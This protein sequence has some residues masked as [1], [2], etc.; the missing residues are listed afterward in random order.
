MRRF[1]DLALKTA[2]LLC[3]ASG[4][5]AGPDSA[6]KEALDFTALVI[7]PVLSPVPVAATDERRHL[8]YEILIVNETDLY[9]RVD[10]IDAFDPAGGA[11]LGQWKDEALAKIFRINGK[12]PGLTLRPGASAYAFLDAAVDKG[13][14]VPKVVKHRITTSRFMSKTPDGENLVPL[15]PKFGIP[16]VA[17]FEGAKIAVDPGKPL[18]IEPP[19]G[20][21]GWVAF[22]GCCANLQHRGAVMA[23]N[24]VPKIPERFAIDFMKLDGSHR[25]FSGPAARVESYAAYGAPVYAVANGTVIE[26][27]DGAP[28]RTPTKPRDPIRFDNAGGNDVVID[29]GGGHYAYFAHLKTGTVAVKR[30]DRVRTGDIIGYLGNT[31]NSDAPHLHFH[32]MDGPSPFASNGIPYVFSTFSAAGRL[33]AGNDQLL[34]TGAPA[35]LDSRRGFGARKAQLPLDLEIVDF[36]DK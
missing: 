9:V 19:L 1:L 7:E 6:R 18:I 10:Q 28:E 3:V 11:L 22:N 25:L 16:A 36:P 33:A 5:A 13:A 4:A 35:I 12:L 17:T 8:V 32:I 30:G 34:E 24:G 15:D 29:I 14:P 27:S 26:T 23:F 31:G 2:A 21:R 20:G